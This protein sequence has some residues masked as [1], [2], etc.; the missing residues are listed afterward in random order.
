MALVRR[1]SGPLP[2]LGRVEPFS[3][4]LGAENVEHGCAFLKVFVRVE[5]GQHHYR[6]NEITVVPFMW[7]GIVAPR[8]FK[9]G[10]RR[11][12]HPIGPRRFVGECAIQRLQ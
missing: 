9:I 4:R 7:S 12:Q 5:H 1:L 6:A 10:V 11:R 3:Q 8:R 2:D